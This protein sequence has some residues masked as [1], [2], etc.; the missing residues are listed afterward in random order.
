MDNAFWTIVNNRLIHDPT[1]LKFAAKRR[2]QGD[3]RNEGLRIF[4]RYIARETFNLIIADL[5]PA[6]QSHSPLPVDIGAST[7]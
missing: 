6:P 2:L 5:R 4:K 1:T 3:R 7:R